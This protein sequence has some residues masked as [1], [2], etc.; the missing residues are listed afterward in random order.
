M[1]E[2]GLISGYLDTLSG[3]LPG[4]VVE[5]L[6]DGLEETCRRNLSLGLT[7]DAAAAAAV[8]EF[9]APELIAAEFARAHPARRAARH[10]LVTGPVVGSCW[11]VALILSRA[12]TW[13]VPMAADLVPGLALAAVV[14]LLA[15]AA[16]STRYRPIGRA[17]AA[18]CIGTAALDT[19]MIISVL[20]ADPAAGWAVAVAITA[21][22]ARLAL[23]MRLV[24]PV[25]AGNALH[26]RAAALDHDDV[27]PAAVVL[28][29]AF[30][31]PDH[32]EPGGPVQGHAGGVLREDARLDG[33]DPGGLGRGDQRG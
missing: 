15:F 29:D 22:T 17:G 24:R 6:A 13:P 14:A 20:A 26:G 19:F 12:W 28:A 33:P 8:A 16:R 18:G 11:A 4:P 25:L 5:E 27:A 30:P 7:P 3:Q 2:P 32:T 23:T 31:G 10:M 1:P 9:G 21:S